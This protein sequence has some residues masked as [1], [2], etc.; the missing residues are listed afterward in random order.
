MCH[1]NTSCDICMFCS[2]ITISYWVITVPHFAITLDYW[3]ITIELCSIENFC[4][5][6]CHYRVLLCCNWSIL[7]LM[8]HIVS[9]L[10]HIES[11]HC[12]TI[13]MFYSIIS[14]SLCVI[15]WSFVPSLCSLVCHYFVI[16]NQKEC[17]AVLMLSFVP[18]L[19]LS[20]LSLCLFK[21]TL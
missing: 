2:A 14:V 12:P 13:T 3:A 10:C 1:Q 20:M 18:L 8:C 9:S 21:S 19:W 6:S 7:P 15:A 5:P 4:V 16:L 17:H 11:S